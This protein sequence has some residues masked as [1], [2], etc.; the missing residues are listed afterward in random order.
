MSRV[1]NHFQKRSHEELQARRSNTGS[2]IISGAAGGAVLGSF[3]GFSGSVIGAVA[4]AV[5]ATAVTVTSHD[6]THS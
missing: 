3:A 4:G 1:D 2:A 6:K 5:V